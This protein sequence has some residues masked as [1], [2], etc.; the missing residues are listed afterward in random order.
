MGW[1]RKFLKVYYLNDGRTVATGIHPRDHSWLAE[2]QQATPHWRQVGTT[3]MDAYRR[4]QAAIADV[5]SHFSHA[6]KTDRL[7]RGLQ[8]PNRSAAFRIAQR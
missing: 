7:I 5:D 3:L 4:R 1:H 6:L 2:A 8:K